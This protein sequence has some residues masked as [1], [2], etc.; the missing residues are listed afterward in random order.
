MSCSR[1]QGLMV[2]EHFLDF[3][4]TIGHMWAH[5]FRCMNCGNVHDPVIEQ[6]RRTRPEPLRIVPTNEL[7]YH[8]DEFDVDMDKQ[9]VVKLVA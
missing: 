4:G 3:D 1:C 5:G 6:H 2:K 7:D 9:P 8:E